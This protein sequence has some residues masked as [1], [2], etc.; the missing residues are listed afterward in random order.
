MS[1][2]A[3]LAAKL[4][5]VPLAI[6]PMK[7]EIVMGVLAER[8][9]IVS[10]DNFMPREAKNYARVD[11]DALAFRESRETEHDAEYEVI[12]GAAVIPI[13]GTLVNKLGTLYPYSGMTGYDGIRQN[14]EVALDDPTVKGI[15]FDVES[16]GGEVSGCFDLADLIY[17]NRNKKP[18]IAICSDHA[19]SAAFALASA[20]GNVVIPRTGGLGSVGVIVIATEVSKALQEAGIKVSLIT[21]GDRKADGRPEIPLSKEARERIQADVD[22]VGQLFC[23]TVARNLNLPVDSVTNTSAGCFMGKKALD[24]G[25]AKRIASPEE[26]FRDF[27]K[28]L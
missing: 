1:R 23:E 12:A 22:T 8:L 19:Y 7:A 9:G 27:V 2:H 24:V 26:A 5:N 10:L 15:C 4:F 28:S 11:A 3:Y 6:H 18:H 17:A 13:E 20:T 16:P 21:Y 25:F 14:Y